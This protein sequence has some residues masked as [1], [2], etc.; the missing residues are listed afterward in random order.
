MSCSQASRIS[1]R[2]TQRILLMH[3]LIKQK[4]KT[5]LIASALQ[6]KLYWSAT[7]SSSSLIFNILDLLFTASSFLLSALAASKRCCGLHELNHEDTA[8]A[9]CWVQSSCCLPHTPLFQV[10]LPCLALVLHT[11]HWWYM[12]PSSHQI[13]HRRTWSRRGAGALCPCWGYF[14]WW[15]FPLPNP[16]IWIRA[17]S[18][19]C[20]HDK[21]PIASSTM[22]CLSAGKKQC[23]AWTWDFWQVLALPML[24]CVAVLYSLQPAKAS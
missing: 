4:C 21:W 23:C 5:I 7:T 17:M 16:Q 11:A 24:P 22:S 3:F 14:R 19:P 12:V 10:P 1:K 15:H 8:L 9:E 2:I 18:V 13:Q 6:S 20:S